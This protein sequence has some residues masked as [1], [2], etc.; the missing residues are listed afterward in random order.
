[1]I[2][3]L[4]FSHQGVTVAQYTTGGEW[5]RGSAAGRDVVAGTAARARA[6]PAASDEGSVVFAAM[7][8][9]DPA[10]YTRERPGMSAVCARGRQRLP[11]LFGL[12]ARTGR[13]L[14]HVPVA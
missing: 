9:T 2:A 7:S 11:H 12:F 4:A 3:F 14:G 8:G 1:M 5:K 10:T 13:P 6:G